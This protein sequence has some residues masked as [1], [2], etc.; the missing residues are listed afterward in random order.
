MLH[1]FIAGIE[2][3]RFYIYLSRE[4]KLIFNTILLKADCCFVVLLSSF[5]LGLNLQKSAKVVLKSE[6]SK[7]K[8]LSSDSPQVKLAE[9][10]LSQFQACPSPP[11]AICHFSL[12]KLQMPHGGA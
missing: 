5:L 11:P 3:L 6:K 2:W 8:Y 10:W 1:F 9:L 12:E 7:L 4:G